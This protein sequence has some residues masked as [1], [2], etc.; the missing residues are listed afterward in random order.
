MAKTSISYIAQVVSTGTILLNICEFGIPFT[1]PWL[2]PVMEC[3]Y[4]IYIGISM[5]ASAGMY[6]ILWSTQCV[7]LYHKPPTVGSGDPVTEHGPLEYF[8][9]TP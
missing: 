5:V 9:S 1:G 4:W 2:I 8:L 7:L 3:L 6:L